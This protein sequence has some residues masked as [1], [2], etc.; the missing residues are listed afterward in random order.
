MAG[1][2][3]QVAETPDGPDRH[4]GRL[5]LTPEPVHEYFDGVGTDFIGHAI[6]AIGKLIFADHPACAQQQSF[7]QRHLPRGQIQRIFAHESTTCS[8][9]EGEGAMIDAC[10]GHGL[11]PAHQGAYTGFELGEL[12]RLD[13]IVV[14]ADIQ[15]VYAIDDTV[16]RG[17]NQH[18][19]VGCASPETTKHLQAIQARQAQV[20]NHQ[21]ER[22]D[23]QQLIGQPALGHEAEDEAI[24]T[25]TDGTG[26][27]EALRAALQ[28]ML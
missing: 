19:N 27:S 4:P 15:T 6:Q 23:R 11:G 12:E 8:R 18:R 21:I 25:F 26:I 3:H 14:S 5:D 24:A 17:Q 13:Q 1:L 16:A 20:Q 9:I 28:T 7:Q 2:F 22:V 10:S